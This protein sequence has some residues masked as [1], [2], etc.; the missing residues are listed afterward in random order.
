MIASEDG[1]NVFNINK[2]DSIQNYEE[3]SYDIGRSLLDYY[4]KHL[5]K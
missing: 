4:N 2:Q 1:S 5:I 3:L